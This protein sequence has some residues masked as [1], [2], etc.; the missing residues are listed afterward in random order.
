MPDPFQRGRFS[1]L[2]PSERA[3]K[4]IGGPYLHAS[5]TDQLH[6]VWRGQALRPGRLGSRLFC[7]I[8]QALPSQRPS[9]AGARMHGGSV[10]RNPDLVK[11]LEDD[12]SVLIGRGPGI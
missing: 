1:G 2:L 11:M 5:L 8:C 10:E 3:S 12:G 9:C 7:P 6:P 4:L